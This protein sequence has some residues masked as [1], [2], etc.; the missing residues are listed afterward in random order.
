MNPYDPLN[1]SNILGA[2]TPLTHPY[3]YDP[4]PIFNDGTEDHT[5]NVHTDR[6]ISQ[7]PQKYDE[8]CRTHFD[9]RGHAFDKRPPLLI[10]A[11]LRDYFDND[12]IVLTKVVQHCN[13]GNG[14][15]YWELFF[16]E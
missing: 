2:K 11:W 12:K 5:S 16:R 1:L 14:Y 7:N 15:P 4:F 6:L 10:Q 8:V 13:V 9:G 3:N